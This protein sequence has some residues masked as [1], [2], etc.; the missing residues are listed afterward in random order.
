MSVPRRWR[1]A[2]CSRPEE[3]A[4]FQTD[5]VAARNADRRDGGARR[6]IERAYNDFWW[7]WGDALTED[8]RTSLIVDPPSGRLPPRQ[9]GIDEAE[10]TRRR[11]HGRPVRAPVV[12]GSPAHGPEDLGLSERCLVGFNAGPP[13]LPSAYNNNVQLLTTPTHVVVLNEMVHDAR[14]VSTRPPSPAS[15]VAAALAGAFTGMV[16]RRHAGG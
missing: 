10:A 8:R 13:M 14:I 9:P 1:I 4:A 6:D 5:A 7:D 12:I 15:L 16:A 3:A 2:R 11:T